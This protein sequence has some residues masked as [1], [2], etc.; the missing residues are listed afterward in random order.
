[1]KKI[2]LSPPHLGTDEMKYVQ[3]AF[4]SNW[5]APVGENITVFQEQL[6]DLLGN[7]TG[8]TVVSSGTAAIHLALIMLG[9][10]S[11]DEVICQ[12]FTF[13]ASINPILYQHATPVL[14]DSEK[15]SWNMCPEQLERAIQTRMKSGKKPKAIILV[16]LYGMPCNMKELLEI[17]NRYEIPV[18]EDAAEAL[19][20]KFDG[21]AC[22]TFGEMG[23]LSFNGNK[24]ITA[25]SGGAI[26]SKN[27][28]YISQASFYAGQSKDPALFYKHSKIGY[29]YQ[30]SNILAGIGR[31]QMHVLQERIQARRNI[32][33]FYR[34][35]LADV[36]G[37]SFQTEPDER[38]FSNYWLTTVL[39]DP[40]KIKIS[41]LDVCEKMNAQQIECRPLWNPM[42][43]QPLFKDVHYFGNG[44]SDE[45]FKQGIC[46]PSGS[47]MSEE[48]LHKISYQ[49]SVI[50]KQ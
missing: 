28:E 50:S 3:D 47:S 39:L 24:I 21:Q 46:L 29:N 18:I 31:G 37:I 16:D 13:S 23:V 11:G 9:V 30:L 19:G 4:D 5:I 34:K 7:H 33:A 20:S 35:A 45:L 43:L 6:A 27:P 22:G 12:S 44:V 36:E 8:V 25:S 41:P 2:Y 10:E 38:F 42:H 48:D 15:D 49:L 26:A 14:V 40:K 17:A 1:M 32:N